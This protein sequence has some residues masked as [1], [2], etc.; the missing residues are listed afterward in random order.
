[1]ATL[2]LPCVLS[3]F[4]YADGEQSMFLVT[5]HQNTCDGVDKEQAADLETGADGLVSV[6]LLAVDH[7]HGDAPNQGDQI[8]AQT[9]KD[10][11]ENHKDL[12]GGS[13]AR[14]L[15][16]ANRISCTATVDADDSIIGQL[17]ATFCA[18]LHM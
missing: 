7:S 9:H 10:G 17:S 4:A 3:I 14:G 1:M 6:D 16:G 2:Y 12:S 5:Q 11:A 18:I 13:N 8:A 15:C